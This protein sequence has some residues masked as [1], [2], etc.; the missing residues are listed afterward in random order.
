[1]SDSG[2]LTVWDCI[3]ALDRRD[4]RV[5]HKGRSIGA[6]EGLWLVGRAYGRFF[7]ITAS[8]GTLEALGAYVAGLEESAA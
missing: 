2:E 8:F 7:A 1:M 3:R 6:E 4:L 5:K